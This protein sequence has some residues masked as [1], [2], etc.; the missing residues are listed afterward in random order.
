MKQM[1]NTTLEMDFNYNFDRER[2]SR[3]LEE[4]LTH[5]SFMEAV[6]A[7]SRFS[8]F[9]NASAIKSHNFQ[10]KECETELLYEENKVRCHCQHMSFYTV[11]RDEYILSFAETERT[12]NF[13]NW[14]AFTLVSYLILVIIFGLVI[15]Q[16]KDQ[17]DIAKLNDIDLEEDP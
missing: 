2:F 7:S 14:A 16:N 6:S 3:S 9:V 10:T 5:C 17:K 13:R 15:S 1:G 11:T 8:P 4:R 12:F